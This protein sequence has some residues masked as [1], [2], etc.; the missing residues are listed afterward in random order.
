MTNIISETLVPRSV[1]NTLSTDELKELEIVFEELARAENPIFPAAK[2][3]SSNRGLWYL[4]LNDPFKYSILQLAAIPD[5]ELKSMLEFD[6]SR[7]DTYHQTFLVGGTVTYSLWGQRFDSAMAAFGNPNITAE[8]V[9]WV[10][11]ALATSEPT[12]VGVPEFYS[13]VGYQLLDKWRPAGF[14]AA[15]LGELVRSF[16]LHGVT[17]YLPQFKRWAR[18]A[19]AAR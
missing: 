6:A 17:E 12:D 18:R 2:L 1:V 15:V 14:N 10:L 16:E 11:D 7:L 4:A 19:Q 13:I 5:T 8:T 9:A 3:K